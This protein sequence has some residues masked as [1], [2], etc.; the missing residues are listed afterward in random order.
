M[1]ATLLLGIGVG[2]IIGIVIA[3][4]LVIGIIAWAISI[5]NKC[6]IL[7]IK[8][9]EAESDIDVA[10][11]KRFDLLTKQLDIVK[12][13][14]KHE[15]ETLIAVTEM[16]ANM[17]PK[18][19]SEANASMDSASKQINI[20]AEQYP[21][22]KANTNFK[23]L[24]VVTADVEEHLQASRRVFNANVNK[25]NAYIVVFPNNII[26][27]MLKCKPY[28]FF[29]AEETKKQDIKMEF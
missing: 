20:L 29:E 24:Q 7:K 23:E 17:S 22:L 9:E 26:A 6:H 28:E 19:K 21:D 10:L 5:R 18:E 13:Y 8:I 25:Y 15:K 2:G 3:V 1:K 14:A 12:G 4:A 11:T 16:R 27:N